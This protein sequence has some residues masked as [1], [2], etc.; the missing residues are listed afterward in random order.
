MYQAPFPL[1]LCLLFVVP[2]LHAWLGA[3]LTV[4][5]P[6]ARWGRRIARNLAELSRPACITHVAALRRHGA[7][8]A[9]LSLPVRARARGNARMLTA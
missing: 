5:Q 8:H 2:S 4:A 1:P 6:A 9:A 3:V 7:Q